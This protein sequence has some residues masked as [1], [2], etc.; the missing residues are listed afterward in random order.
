[1]KKYLAYFF[2]VGLLMLSAVQYAR[3]EE[4]PRNVTLDAMSCVSAEAIIE[5]TKNVAVLGVPWKTAL[6]QTNGQCERHVTN[7][8]WFDPVHTFE[9]NGTKFEVL[10]V[11]VHAKFV[12]IAPGINAVEPWDGDRFVIKF[13]KAQEGA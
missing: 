8:D 10:P 12:P 3:A 2:I 4:K 13:S 9:V 7:F 1:V 6:A 5:Y 11:K